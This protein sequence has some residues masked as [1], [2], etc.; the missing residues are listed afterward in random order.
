MLVPVSRTSW[1]SHI[2][3]RL[4][5]QEAHAGFYSSNWGLLPYSFSRAPVETIDLKQVSYLVEKLPESRFENPDGGV[6]SPVPAPGGGVDV[7][8]PANSKLTIPFAGPFPA[9]VQFECVSQS[10]D[11]CPLRV[12]LSGSEIPLRKMKGGLQFDLTD[13]HNSE[14]V[15]Q[16][17]SPVTI[18][19]W[20]MLPGQ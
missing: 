18:R 17:A 15:L 10:P 12:Q 16:T 1:T 3:I 8:I 7:V 20:L 13:S 6:I 2:P 9:R 19:N 4:M 14:I 11:T 5:N